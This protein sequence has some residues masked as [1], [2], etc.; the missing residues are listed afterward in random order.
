[1]RTH[2]QTHDVALSQFGADP[3]LEDALR[4]VERTICACPAGA[5]STSLRAAEALGVEIRPTLD[6]IVLTT[7]RMF[8][9]FSSFTATMPPDIRKS[10][11]EDIEVVMRK[12]PVIRALAQMQAMTDIIVLCASAGAPA[13]YKWRHTSMQLRPWPTLSLLEACSAPAQS[14]APALA[15]WKPRPALTLLMKVLAL[16]TARY[17]GR[18]LRSG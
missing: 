16:T 9:S 18:A 6:A 3:A 5:L 17:G 10:M 15:G 8:D 1:M 7:K 14:G 13:G 12:H 4:A 2:I 11:W